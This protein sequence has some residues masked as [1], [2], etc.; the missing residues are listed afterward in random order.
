MD[1]RSPHWP[2]QLT[3]A[4]LEAEE[5]VLD[6]LS[7]HAEPGDNAPTA[8]KAHAGVVDEW[9]PGPAIYRR[10]PE[11]LAEMGGEALDAPSVKGALAACIDAMR[12]GVPGPWRGVI[13]AV[14]RIGQNAR[15]GRPNLTPYQRG[16]ATA[17]MRAYQ[18]VLDAEKEKDRRAERKP[19]GPTPRERAAKVIASVVHRRQFADHEIPEALQTLDQ[20]RKAARRKPR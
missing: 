16:M 14:A 11:L 19:K 2:P 15:P 13:E 1:S 4:E 7:R 17:Q 10:L 9:L 3:P 5:R 18:H 8:T 20:L 6:W 12:H